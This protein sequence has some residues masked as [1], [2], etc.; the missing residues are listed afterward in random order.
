MC[1]SLIDEQQFVILVDDYL[2]D[3]RASQAAGTGLCPIQK[4]TGK[5]HIDYIW[6]AS[7]ERKSTWN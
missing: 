4:S 5:A 7:L 3:P 2:G 6:T 1:A